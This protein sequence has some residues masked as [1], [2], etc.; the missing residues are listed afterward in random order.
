MNTNSNRTKVKTAIIGATGYVGQRLILLLRNHPYF[1]LTKL[2][3]SSK[4]AGKTYAE[5]MKEKFSLP[6]TS[7]P[8]YVNTM[9]VY[10]T[11]DINKYFDEF[12]LVFCAVD[13][14]KAD[15]MAL[16]DRLAKSGK[17]VV[18][19]NSANRLNP[20]VPCII[21]EINYEHLSLI[22]IQQKKLSYNK[23]FIVCK[24]NCSIQSY[25]PALTPLKKFGLTKI[26]VSTY[27][28]ISGAGKNFSTWPEM[29]ANLI[30]YI[31]GEE[32]K[33]EMEPLK[34][35]AELKN[36]NFNDE[37]ELIYDQ[38]NISA[39]CYRVPVLEGHT[40]SI[41]FELQDKCDEES[42]LKTWREF[43][44]SNPCAHLPTAPKSFLLYHPEENMPQL[45]KTLFLNDNL[46]EALKNLHNSSEL[47][48]NYIDAGMSIHLGRLRKDKIFS[49]KLT[50]LSHNTLRGA[51]GGSVLTAELL[52]DRGF[53]NK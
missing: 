40:A 14:S 1:E 53:L 23:G 6:E 41:W 12:E 26:V 11:A 22:E 24:P 35:W 17:F 8:A 13:M 31:A 32:E 4:S 3:A 52:Y 45:L 9:S 47:Y 16:E 42:I 49:Y 30:P 37:P 25:L 44:E 34:I 5:C 48:K 28:A 43:N 29:Q 51:A 21:P 27:Q 20:L 38:I 50:C 46:S 36:K 15:I 18:S 19:N 39:Q 10:D 2:F 7:I 33:S